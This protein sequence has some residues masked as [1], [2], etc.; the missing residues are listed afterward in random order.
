MLKMAIIPESSY[1]FDPPSGPGTP[2][3]SRPYP[4]PPR[5]APHLLYDK[6]LSPQLQTLHWPHLESDTCEMVAFRVYI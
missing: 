3:S 4:L 2:L 5:G 1:C 6:P